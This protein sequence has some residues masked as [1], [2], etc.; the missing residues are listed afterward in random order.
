[1][2]SISP[3]GS[4][5]ASGEGSR[6]RVP[7]HLE[8]DDPTLTFVVD[9]C[10]LDQQ[11]S[12]GF[13]IELVVKL[14]NPVQSVASVIGLAVRVVLE[15]E[16]TVPP[17]HTVCTRLR[18]VSSDYEW[19]YFAMRLEPRT[20]FL[21]LRRNSR[22]FK[23]MD[24]TQIA[25]ALV[26]PVAAIVGDV[27]VEP[28]RELPIHGYRVQYEESD[29]DAL[30]R[31]L[32]EDG[33]TFFYD[34]EKQTSLHL[35]ARTVRLSAGVRRVP[36]LPGASLVVGGEPVA[37]R[38]AEV[39]E[40]T[41]EG[42]TVRDAW[43]EKPDFEA[44]GFAKL[45]PDGVALAQYFFDPHAENT[46]A[47]LERQARLR[48]FE[49]AMPAHAVEVETN[50]F[51]HAGSALEIDRAPV[52]LAEGPL[53]VVRVHSEWRAGPGRM[54][55]RHVAT[56]IPKDRHWF[57]PR[58][59]PLK[60]PGIQ[61]ATVVGDGEIDVDELGRVLCRFRWD[62]DA[63]VSRR[64]EVSQA[65]AGPSYG[66][67]S[68]PRV[69]HEVLVAYLDGDPDE[70]IVVGRVHD[71]KNLPPGD[72]PKAKNISIWG[73]LSTPGGQGHQ[74]LGFD[75]SAGDELMFL[76]AQKDL[77]A[78]V[79]NDAKVSVG[80]DFDLAVARNN[81]IVVTELTRVQMVGNTTWEAANLSITSIGTLRI[82]STGDY[83]LHVGADHLVTVDGF[84]DRHV[85]GQY[86]LSSATSIA[87]IVEG[88][89]I[90]MTPGKIELN[91]DGASIV[92]SAG[93]I[94]Q[95]ANLISLNP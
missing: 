47:E 9:S 77:T 93:A 73:G 87:L 29:W 92:L 51:L 14:A 83:V 62:R 71:G 36:Y 50:A 16:P 13:V 54:I 40:Q 56:C 38:V 61:R 48:L 68:H 84:E 5:A 42:V 46:E 28:T 19:S 44:R 60:I 18:Y 90:V 55:T 45:G 70:P 81:N 25:A 64:V 91:V 57:P 88:S 39:V 1:M 43:T 11:L 32:A 69:G 75:D 4:L 22:I 7:L 12:D 94:T 67:A 2:S 78:E 37:I 30:R 79:L 26:A 80:R 95:I 27:L 66:H 10:T 63:V 49:K 24:A 59:P 65:W 53:L 52:P 74:H 31:L 89:S 15:E 33:V 86:A 35:V 82:T 8:L 34:L 41:I 85:E 58:L 21:R 23:D 76:R 6:S 20:C 3:L 72:L 17:I